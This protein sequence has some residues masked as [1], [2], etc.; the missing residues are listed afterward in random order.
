MPNN[1]GM[2]NLHKSPRE[3]VLHSDSDIVVIVTLESTNRK[4]GDMIQAWIICAQENPVSAVRNGSASIVCGDCRHRGNGFK[5]RTCYV[6]VGQGPNAVYRAFINGS[7]P[8]LPVSEYARVFTGRKIRLGAY[9][10]PVLIP[11]ELVRLMVSHSSG[12]TGYTHQWRN[13]KHALYR[14]YVMA[15]VDTPGERAMAKS[16]GW[17][18]FRVRAAH[19]PIASDEITCPASDEAGRKTTCEKCRLC[20]GARVDDARRDIAIQVHG[21]GAA[22]FVTIQ[23]HA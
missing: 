3:Y 4:T 7:Y 9:G 15:S 2:T 13:P 18:T 12:H 1:Y 6:N 20:N 11:L 21:S 19:E 10:D 17:R 22:Q 5:G 16:A 8:Y 14:E 23:M